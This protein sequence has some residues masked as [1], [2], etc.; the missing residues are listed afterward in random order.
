[1]EFIF[2]LTPLIPLFPLLA[3]AI[4]VLFTHRH[5]RLSSS[6]AIGGIALSTAL[7]W[8][9]VLATILSGEHA[10]AEG[11]QLRVPWLPAGTT[12][13]ELG[14]AVDGFTAA[15]LFMVPF[16]CL[17]IFIYSQGYMKLGQPDQ[18][19]RYAR[20]F[21]YIS[22][23]AAG[24]LGLVVAR[25]L[26][27]LFISW[28]VMGLCSYLLIGFW[29]FRKADS[30]H[31]IDAAQVVRARQAALKAFI[32]TR[33]GDVLLFSGIALLYSYTGT[34]TFRE[35]FRPET[36]ETLQAISLLGMPAVTVIALLVFGGAVG[37]SAQFPLHVW[38]PDAMEGP[39]PVS[40]LIHAATMVAAGVYLVART[41]PLF[42][43]GF[44]VAD[45]PALHWV[46]VIGAIT[47]LLGAT[48]GLA[49]DDIKRVLAYST[50]SQ[51]GYM[52]MGL[53]L[54]SLVAGIF[55][56]LTHAFFKALLFLSAGSVIHGVEHGAHIAAHNGHGH[57]EHFSP[58]DMKIMGGLRHR[59]PRTFVAY[60]A[61]AL[62][63]VG[64][65]PFAGFWS[66]DEIL[67]EAF[68]LWRADGTLNL[69]FWVWLA[70]T[71]G[72]FFTA[73]Y[74]GRQLGL[75]FWGEPRHAAARHAHESPSS[76]TVPLIV[77]ALFALLFG[78]V[79]APFLGN[80]L[81]HLMGNVHEVS[82]VVHAEAIPFNP[83]VAGIS[84]VLAVA[85]LLLGWSLY[86]NYRA[87][88]VEPFQAALGPVF[89]VLRN[90][91]YIDDLY[92]W[93]I[94]RPAVWLANFCFN[95]DDRWI[96]DPFVDLVGAAGRAAS[97]IARVLDSGVIDR[98]FVEGTAQLFNAA[99]RWLRYSETGHVQNYLLVV[100]VTILLLLGL[101]LY[102]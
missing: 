67:A 33:I 76:M 69:P 50:I 4:I 21:A 57:G 36:L 3:F 19:P 43:A 27:L 45:A 93:A 73:L 39:T 2:N 58:N 85:G 98:W 37:K 48:V 86:R 56:L 31:H 97:D 101:Y 30:E 74:M 90:K 82:E 92:Q 22:L 8:T 70:G 100:A 94:I 81:H 61:G 71:L 5:N 17:M 16:V 26:V 53:G 63:L 51:L 18:D 6:I 7:G 54:G 28:E 24:M 75:V 88:Q 78:F 89:T 25:D 47:A 1:M 77:L 79:N 59:M 40:A 68:H 95:I 83:T 34:L 41:L 80:P 20:F 11:W 72:A 64:I 55:H 23:F 9:L 10:W 29:S 46:A 42:I 66:K 15:M 84:T 60:L 62:A 102:F 99:G 13:L 12:V 87:G 38:L 14:F 35:L 44:V 96:I 32:T 65:V 52:M 49:Q 91:Y